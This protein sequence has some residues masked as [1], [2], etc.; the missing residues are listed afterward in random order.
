MVS[1]LSV[2]SRL[3]LRARS[4]DPVWVPGMI[5]DGFASLIYIVLISCNGSWTKTIATKRSLSR[6][7]ATGYKWLAS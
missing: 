7:A 3:S 6:P 5:P 4:V 1:T 2:F